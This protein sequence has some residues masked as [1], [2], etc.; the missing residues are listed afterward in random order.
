[1]ALQNKQISNSY[2]GGISIDK[3]WRWIE[4]VV[5]TTDFWEV[6]PT[7]IPSAYTYTRLHLQ[8]STHIFQGQR[9]CASWRVSASSQTFFPFP[10]WQCAKILSWSSGGIFSHILTCLNLQVWWILE[11]FLLWKQKKMQYFFNK[12]KG[13]NLWGKSHFAMEDTSHS[14]IFSFS[15]RLKPLLHWDS[16][17]SWST[18][19]EGIRL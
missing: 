11:H 7:E 4:M 6:N 2:G 3:Y 12:F 13:N 9:S 17:A 14:E 18:R 5:C 19:G 15:S 10:A 8:G 16:F 1:M